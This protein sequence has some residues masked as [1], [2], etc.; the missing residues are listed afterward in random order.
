MQRHERGDPIQELGLVGRIGASARVGLEQRQ[1]QA[2]SEVVGFELA[3][4][5]PTL[6]DAYGLEQGVP[7]LRGTQRNEPGRNPNPC[8]LMQL[9]L[10]ELIETGDVHHPG[11]DDEAALPRRVVE[12]VEVHV[13]CYG[14]R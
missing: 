4:E 8:R 14:V 7:E 2:C 12:D 5:V 13:G 3:Q 1:D 11:A 9:W 6:P 10:N